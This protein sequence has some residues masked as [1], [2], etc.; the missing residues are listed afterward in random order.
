MS[1]NLF[2][3]MRQRECLITMEKNKIINVGVLTKNYVFNVC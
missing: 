3:S 1:G 2:Q